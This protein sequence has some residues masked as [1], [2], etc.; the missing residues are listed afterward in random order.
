MFTPITVKQAQRYAQWCDAMSAEN[1]D[2]LNNQ[3][4][5]L[6][7]KNSSQN[8]IDYHRTLKIK[9]DLNGSV[10]RYKARLL[11]I[12][13]TQRPSIYFHDAFSQI[14]MILS[15]RLVNPT[16]HYKLGSYCFEEEVYMH[17]PPGFVSKQ[18]PDYICT[19]QNLIYGLR[20]ASHDI[21]LC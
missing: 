7:P 8:I 15:V 10:E 3:T 14:F 4:R 1:D 21:V 17:Q 12:R 19:L 9:H 11:E 20:Q 18:H 16:I 13:F 2:F 6:V 5:N